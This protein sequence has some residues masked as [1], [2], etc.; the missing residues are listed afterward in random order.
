MSTK[1]I[2]TFLAFHTCYFCWLFSQKTP[3]MGINNL[4]GAGTDRVLT[5][6][7]ITAQ[8]CLEIGFIANCS[9]SPLAFT[10]KSIKN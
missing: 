10:M 5:L 8:N 3:S 4:Y 6:A 1:L 2:I 7:G 9:L